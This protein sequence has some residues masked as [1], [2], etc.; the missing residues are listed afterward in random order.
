MPRPPD[1]MLCSST[2]HCRPLRTNA[3][4]MSLCKPCNTTGDCVF[5]NGSGLHVVA[6]CSNTQE[7]DTPAIDKKDDANRCVGQQYTLKSLPWHGGGSSRSELDIYIYIYIY[8]NFPFVPALALG[9]KIPPGS[10]FDT[11]ALRNHCGASWARS[12]PSRAGAGAE[13]SWAGEGWSIGDGLGVGYGRVV[14]VAVA[15]AVAMAA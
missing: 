4:F 11:L 8:G 1:I 3:T 14:A 12:G 9:C 6:L 2:D 7:A 10:R 5:G 13:P 15:M